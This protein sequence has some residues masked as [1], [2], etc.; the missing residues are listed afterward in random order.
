MICSLPKD[1][2]GQIRTYVVLINLT[3]SCNL[4]K[5]ENAKENMKEDRAGI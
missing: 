2:Y 1:Y 3:L 5:P 4:E